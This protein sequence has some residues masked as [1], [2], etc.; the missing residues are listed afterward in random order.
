M[1]VSRNSHTAF[2]STKN[3]QM[4]IISRGQTEL[5]QMNAYLISLWSTQ[6]DII[7]KQLFHTL[8]KIIK[9]TAM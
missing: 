3:T 6:S 2:Y 4:E 1:Y 8:P 9:T 5:E 7:T